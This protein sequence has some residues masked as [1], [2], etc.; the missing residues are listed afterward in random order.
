MSPLQEGVAWEKPRVLSPSLRP[1][2]HPWD[3]PTCASG[4]AAAAP[5]SR[6]VE[7]SLRTE[8]KVRRPS[9]GS[10]GLAD[11]LGSVTLPGTLGS[12]QGPRD[13]QM[14]P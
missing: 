3:A 13:G 12:R 7:L 11:S 4:V 6:S 8:S 2:P 1:R 10:E 5:I 9:E 14:A